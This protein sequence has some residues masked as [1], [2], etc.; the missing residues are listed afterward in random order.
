VKINLFNRNK[1]QEI[2][3]KR[4]LIK[5]LC[6]HDAVAVQ[7]LAIRWRNTLGEEK[8]ANLMANEVLRECDAE[9]HSWFFEA[10]FG[11]LK[12]RQMQQQAQNKVFHIL[13]NAG[14]EAG[15]DFSVGL[16]GEMIISDRA[17]QILL[18]K[19]P[20][21]QR[22]FFEAQLQFFTVADP[23]AA[24]E[25]QLGCPFY[26]NLTEIVACKVQALSDTQAAAYLGVLLAGLVK[27]NPAL[28]DVDFPTKFICNTLKELPP[29]RVTAI[30]NDQETNPQFDELIIFQDLLAAME[31][32]ESVC[33]NEEQQYKNLE[34]L[35]KLDLVWYGEHRL[36]EIVATLKDRR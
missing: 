18:D 11:Q 32:P 25:Q 31:Q 2:K 30:L 15:K 26:K 19:L 21:Q 20:Q 14:L 12:Y 24:I 8:F 5:A 23:I 35:K 36:A 13:I 1:S 7:D 10:C 33:I 17:K 28:Q 3:A 34:Q 16:D 29:Q 9:S 22:K 27:R 6:Q 4:Q